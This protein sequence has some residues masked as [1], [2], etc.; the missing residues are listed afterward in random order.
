M[1][2][3]VRTSQTGERLVAAAAAEFND[4]GFAG[5][6]SN[7][8][9]RRAGFAPQTFYRWFRDKTEI[10][11]AVYRAWEEEERRAIDALLARQ[12]VDEEVVE[13]A[14]AHHRRYLEFRRSLRRLSVEDPQVR[15]ARAQ[16][17]L[18]QVAQI[19]A[20]A[21]AAAKLD[22]GRIAA[23]LLTLER[24][25]DALAEGE[26]A[27]MGVDDA[28]ARREIASIVANLRKGTL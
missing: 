4:H 25:T 28:A 24:L 23:A 5:T 12:A 14:V 17:R 13:A 3:R 21:P 18:R 19:K 6:D 1:D 20:W 27:D 9:A 26:L 2:A 11:V 10:F 8:I 22:D 16:S 7:K 15:R